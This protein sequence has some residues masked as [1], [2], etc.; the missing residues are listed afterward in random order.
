MALGLV[1]SL[2]LCP[3]ARAFYDGH[4]N[5]QRLQSGLFLPLHK[6]VRLELF[7]CWKLDEQDDNSWHDI[8]VVGSSL[9]FL[10]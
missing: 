10:F 1:A 9:Y 8:N 4:F 2:C 6:Q 3:P 7:Y 5:Q